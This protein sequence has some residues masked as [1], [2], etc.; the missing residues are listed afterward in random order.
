[1]IIEVTV[2]GV[3]GIGVS[4]QKCEAGMRVRGIGLRD[5]GVRGIGMRDIGM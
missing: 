3:K 2:L 1:M 5:I 4:R